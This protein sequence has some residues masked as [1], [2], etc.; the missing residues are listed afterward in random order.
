M[1]YSGLN[2][3]KFDEK[4]SELKNY[5]NVISQEK[6]K[7]FWPK[8]KDIAPHDKDIPI[9]ALAL[10]L[11]CPVWSNEIAFKHQSKIKVLST[12]DMIALFP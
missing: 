1:K 10:C 9:F 8:S 3:G 11:N 6:Y 12:R 7:H 5:V 4:I 2:P